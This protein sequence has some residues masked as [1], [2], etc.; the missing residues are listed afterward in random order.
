MKKRK[1]RLTPNAFDALSR[2]ASGERVTEIAESWGMSK[3]AVY[4]TLDR[5]KQELGA[6]N[7]IH[8]VVLFVREFRDKHPISKW[9]APPNSG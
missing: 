9:R 2:L 5:A 4:K 3:A 7:M 1:P 8:A 6:S